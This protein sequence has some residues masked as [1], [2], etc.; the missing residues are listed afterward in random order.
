MGYCKLD[1]EIGYVQGMNIVASVMVYHTCSAFEALKLFQLLMKQINLR[2]IYAS[3]LT[4]GSKVAVVLVEEL[5]RWAFDLY[6]HL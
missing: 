1:S 2:Q 4:F 5:K 3:D 6:S